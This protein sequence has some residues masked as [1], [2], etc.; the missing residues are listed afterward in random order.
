[1]EETLAEKRLEGARLTARSGRASKSARG[2]GNATI[3]TTWIWQISLN[4]AAVLIYSAKDS[5]ALPPTSLLVIEV[6][7]SRLIR[8]L[9]VARGRLLR[10]VRVVQVGMAVRLL[11]LRVERSAVKQVRERLER[12]TESGFG[13]EAVWEASGLSAR[14]RGCRAARAELTDDGNPEE[15]EGSEEEVGAGLR[16]GGSSVWQSETRTDKQHVRR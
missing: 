6:A 3:Q 1:V 13:V 2:E 8:V 14:Q 4:N 16:N 12:A 5:P 11:H 7:S 10:H 9:K 15:V